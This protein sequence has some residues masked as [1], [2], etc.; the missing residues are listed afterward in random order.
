MITTTKNL[1]KGL[2]KLKKMDE[3]FENCSANLEKL[4]KEMRG[5][6][7][8]LKSYK[9]ETENGKYNIRG[10]SVAKHY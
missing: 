3:Y 2:G 4:L 8:K 9:I 1:A 5:D 7:K 10:Y 6:M